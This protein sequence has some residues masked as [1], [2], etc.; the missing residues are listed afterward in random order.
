M[1]TRSNYSDVN[2]KHARYEA[3]CRYP[4]DLN[5]AVISSVSGSSNVDVIVEGTFITFKCFDGSVPTGPN[6]S[7]CMEDGEWSPDPRKVLCTG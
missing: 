3:N 6:I 7:T 4:P 1:F 2:A 5:Q